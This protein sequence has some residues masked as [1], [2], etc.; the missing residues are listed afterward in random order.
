MGSNYWPM[1]AADLRDSTTCR[2]K[3]SPL[4]TILRYPFLV[5]EAKIFLKAPLA[6]I[7]FNFEVGSVKI[8]QKVSKTPFFGLFFQNFACGADILAKT[9][10]L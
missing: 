6:P 7:Y 1:A 2:P 3:G 10:S 5:T 9:V 4:C 8:F